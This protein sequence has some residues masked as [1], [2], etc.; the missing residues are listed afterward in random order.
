MKS[1]IHPQLIRLKAQ[2]SHRTLP[3]LFVDAVENLNIREFR[4]NI[5]SI[6]G[7]SLLVDVMTSFMTIGGYIPD[8]PDLLLLYDPFRDQTVSYRI[9]AELTMNRVGDIRSTYIIT[10]CLQGFGSIYPPQ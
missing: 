1:E 6:V 4:T 7:E 8:C 9:R 3:Y 10:F 2:N 5:T